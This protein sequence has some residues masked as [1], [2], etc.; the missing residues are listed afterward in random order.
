MRAERPP[1]VAGLFYPEDPGELAAQVDG[2]LD[3]A[4]AGP[5]PKALV[6]PHAGYPYSG[7]VAASA[8]ARARPCPWIRR[9]LLLGPSHRTRLEG[10]ALPACRAF[11]TP[12]G[13]VD[14]DPGAPAALAGL[15]G[16]VVSDSPHA[17][18][19][20]LEV[21]L[22]FLQRALGPFLLVPLLVGRCPPQ[23]LARVLEALWGGEETL[24][25][26]STDLSHYLPYQAATA[27][28]EGT[29]RAVEGLRPGDIGDEAAC[30]AH[31]LRGFLRLAAGRRMKVSTLDLRNSGDT[32]GPR[33][34]VV[35][36]GAW[37]FHEREGGAH[38][39]P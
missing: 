35:G 29:C 33:D 27:V 37:A 28:D 13:R 36:Y 34:R 32:A 19:H 39:R 5:A 22:P 21:Q 6:A 3:R 15:P 8:F 2:L 4:G 14:L 26:V 12:L 10:L 24:V 23:D 31:P 9:V 11:A 30:G 20:S 17:R 18:E 25:V 16:L 7:P 1:A 38:G